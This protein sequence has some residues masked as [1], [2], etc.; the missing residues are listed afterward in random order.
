MMCSWKR[1]D[2]QLRSSFLTREDLI[3]FL[4]VLISLISLI[5]LQSF[6]VPHSSKPKPYWQQHRKMVGIAMHPML[7]NF[8]APGAGGNGR[9]SSRGRQ[10]QRQRQRQRR[11]YSFCGERLWSLRSSFGQKECAEPGRESAN[12]R[13]LLQLFAPLNVLSCLLLY[14]KR[15][16]S[17]NCEIWNIFEKTYGEY[18]TNHLVH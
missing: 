5:S 18:V 17:S 8:R 13:L 12:L 14:Y 9:Q 4:W 10:R 7:L 3:H 16:Y 15:H 6:K 1:S 11:Y 2:P